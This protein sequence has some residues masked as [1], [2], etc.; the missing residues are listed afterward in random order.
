MANENQTKKD[1]ES[2]AEQAARELLEAMPTIKAAEPTAKSAVII[3]ALHTAQSSA[4][5]LTASPPNP[6]WMKRWH[7][8]TIEGVQP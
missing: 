4:A 6:S 5:K 2:L 8:Q 1:I 3:Q 7:L